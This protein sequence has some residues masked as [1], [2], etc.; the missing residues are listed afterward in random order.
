M[1]FKRVT[2]IV[3]E[4]FDTA[5]ISPCASTAVASCTATVSTG[6]TPAGKAVGKVH[7]NLPV[8]SV[9]ARVAKRTFDAPAGP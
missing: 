3:A 2:W 7:T 6:N 9:V 4:V 1:L 5:V 8:A